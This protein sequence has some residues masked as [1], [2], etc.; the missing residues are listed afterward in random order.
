MKK[1]GVEVLKHHQHPDTKE[2]V[3]V[4]APCPVNSSTLSLLVP[5][6]LISILVPS[7]SPCLGVQLGFRLSALTETT[8][9]TSYRGLPTTSSYHN[10]LNLSVP[11]HTIHSSVTSK[12]LLPIIKLGPRIHVLP[13]PMAASKSPGR[14]FPQICLISLYR[15]LPTLFI[16]ISQSPSG[17]ETLCFPET[18]LAN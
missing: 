13:E 5:D 8:Q 18:I 14:L 11:S 1:N 9:A 17:A 6:S 12:F 16:I 7:Q 10:S 3:R 2:A 15:C 4:K